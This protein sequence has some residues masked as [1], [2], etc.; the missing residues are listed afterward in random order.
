MGV[1]KKRIA[2]FASGNGSNFE[3]IIQAIENQFLNVI[4]VG[5]VVDKEGA[6]I[7]ERAQNHH[8]PVYMCLRKNFLTKIEMEESILKQLKDWEVDTI[9]CAGYMRIIG[10]T[11]LNAY[12]QNI[13]NIHPSL[14]P[15]YRGVDA[16][17]QALANHETRLGI[18]VHYVDEGVDT[19]AIIKQLEFVVSKE[20]S[21]E[22]IEKKLHTLEHQFY[23]AVLKELL[24]EK[25]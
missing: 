17:G 1:R 22:Q 14:L 3:A 25:Q 2:I 18:T 13:I 6:Y 23:P 9:V 12:K 19:G 15:K 4:C 24:E 10:S 8:I 11:L 20:E 16:L 5:C 21:R 7:I